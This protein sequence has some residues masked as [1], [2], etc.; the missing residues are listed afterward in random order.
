M[1]YALTALA[2]LAS[3]TAYADDDDFPGKSC[4]RGNASFC[5]GPAGPQGPTGPAGPAGPQGPTGPAGPAGPQGAQGPAGQDGAN[6]A[7]GAQ[8]PAGKNGADGA[9]GKDGA[10]GTPAS[11]DWGKIE[12]MNAVSIAIGGLEMPT[13]YANGWSWSAGVGGG[14]KTAISAGLAYGFSDDFFAYGKV[15]WADGAEAY[16]VGVGGRF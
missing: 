5:R 7:D 3:T 13:P 2:V 4:E 8:G 12:A 16:F 6:G 14:D 15:A 10:P 9:D 11:V 1:K